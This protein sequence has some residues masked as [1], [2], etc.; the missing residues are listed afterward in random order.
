MWKWM[1]ATIVAVTVAVSLGCAQ[2][3][4]NLRPVIE[5]KIDRDARIGG[6]DGQDRR[7]RY[8]A[9]EADRASRAGIGPHT[10]PDRPDRT[11]QTED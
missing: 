8:D 3:P 11:V 2:P 4:P 1:G 5:D 7:A 6:S 9:K 10:L